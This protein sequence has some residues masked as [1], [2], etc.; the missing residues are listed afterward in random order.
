MILQ[1]YYKRTNEPCKEDLTKGGV[2]ITGVGA[3]L[4]DE[5]F[6]LPVGLD[7]ELE[8]AIEEFTAQKK[9]KEQKVRQ[10]ESVSASGGVKG[11][12]RLLVGTDIM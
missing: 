8:K 2:G 6:T 7:P 4:L 1:A 12:K 11:A 5:L 10:L 3:K 9:A